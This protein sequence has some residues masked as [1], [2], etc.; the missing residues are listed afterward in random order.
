MSGLNDAGAPDV[1][2]LRMGILA[3]DDHLVALP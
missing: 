3:E 1:V 2:P